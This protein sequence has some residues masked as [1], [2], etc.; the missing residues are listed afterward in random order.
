[1]P[2]SLP[3]KPEAEEW[4]PHSGTFCSVG[5]HLVASLY[6]SESINLTFKTGFFSLN[7]IKYDVQSITK[8]HVPPVFQPYVFPVYLWNRLSYKKSIY[9]FFISVFK[10]LSAGTEIFQIR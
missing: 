4:G 5:A 1:M 9:I 7:L 3:Q 8:K 6:K 2:K 10:E